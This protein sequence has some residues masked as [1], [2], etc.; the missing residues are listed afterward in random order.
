MAGESA[1]IG[2]GTI[3]QIGDGQPVETFIQVARLSNI[4]LNMTRNEANVTNHDTIE[5]WEDFIPTLANGEIPIEGFFISD[6]PTHGTT[7]NGLMNLFRLAAERTMRLIQPATT[8]PYALEFRGFVRNV[9][10]TFP[11][12]DPMGFTATI[13]VKGEPNF[14]YV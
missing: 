12:E 9:N 4:T 5:N 11:V 7:G 13:R 10:Q 6:E 3:L 2:K 8:P 14:D 1:L